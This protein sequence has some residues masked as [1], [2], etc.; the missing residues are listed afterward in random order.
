MA[1]T[2]NPNRGE[3]FTMHEPKRPNNPPP[4]SENW[5]VAELVPLD[6]FT[7]HPAKEPSDPPVSAAPDQTADPPELAGQINRVLAVMAAI[8]QLPESSREVIHL[9]YFED[10]SVEAIAHRLGISR[11]AVRVRLL[12]GLERLQVALTAVDASTSQSPAG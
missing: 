7:M 9:R 10:W 5:R 3:R 8:R 4:G 6:R 2:P 11:E 12:R 1:D